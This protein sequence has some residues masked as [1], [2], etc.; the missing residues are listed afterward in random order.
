VPVACRL[1]VVDR[2]RHGEG[3]TLNSPTAQ[4]S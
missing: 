4:R 1:P 3:G 2:F